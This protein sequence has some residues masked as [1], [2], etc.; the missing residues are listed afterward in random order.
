M[1]PV[2]LVVQ[3]PRC[4]CCPCVGIEW[5]QFAFCDQSTDVNL[6]VERDYQ[7]QIQWLQHCWIRKG[8][9]APQHARYTK[10]SDTKITIT[11]NVF[12]LPSKQISVA[13]FATTTKQ[14]ALHARKR[15]NFQIDW[16]RF[17]QCFHWQSAFPWLARCCT[18]AIPV[19]SAKLCI[20]DNTVISR[21]DACPQSIPRY[22]LTY[23]SQSAHQAQMT[24][25]LHA[26][27][28]V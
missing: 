15:Q 17:H 7:S 4:P 25:I 6:T 9:K 28:H 11:V 20:M 21:M 22:V 13:C 5:N 10:Q 26:C 1:P 3:R 16:L 2:S 27:V 19:H 18:I 24:S 23:T 12:N 8:Q 14:V